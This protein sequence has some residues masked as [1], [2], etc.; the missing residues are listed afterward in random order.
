MAIDEGNWPK[1]KVDLTRSIVSLETVTQ[2]AIMIKTRELLDA[3]ARRLK[4]LVKRV[5]LSACNETRCLY[6]S[7][8]C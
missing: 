8:D 5:P 6:V 7:E 4:P 1:R 3:S 2:L